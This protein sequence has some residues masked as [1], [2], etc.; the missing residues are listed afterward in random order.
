[1]KHTYSRE[2]GMIHFYDLYVYCVMLIE[3]AMNK[4]YVKGVTTLT[5]IFNNHA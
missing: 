5:G 3:Q 2:F 1:M 4:T